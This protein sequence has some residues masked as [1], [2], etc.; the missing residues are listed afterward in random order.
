MKNTLAVLIFCIVPLQFVTANESITLN[1]S[2]GGYSP[3]MI[4]NKAG[5]TSGII[6]D[7]LEAIANKYDHAINYVEIPKHRIESRVLAG[8]IDATPKA[9][10]WVSNQDNFIFTDVIVVAKDVL[11]SPRHTPIKYT[12]PSDL[13]GKMIGINLG[14]YYPRLQPFIEDGKIQTT[15]ATSE[16]LMLKKTLRHRSQGAVVNELVGKWIIKNN[17][18]MQGKFYISKEAINSYEYR[19][20]FNKKW[21]S[22]VSI[23][24]KELAIMKENGDLS[25][26]IKQYY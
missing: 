19:I 14:Y 25:K 2:E 8:T 7:V 12:Q 21:Q 11:F 13:N 16:V 10:E 22:F 23:F 1:I 15:E 18:S 6:I 3:Y 24:N 4:K 26:I 17:P 5:K 9:K 20:M